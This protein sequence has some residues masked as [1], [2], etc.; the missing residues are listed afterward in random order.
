MEIGLLIKVIG[1]CLGSYLLGSIPFG[2]IVSKYAKGIDI[3]KVGSGNI[4]GT[5]VGRILGLRYGAL[6]AGLD[7]W[8]GALPVILTMYFF[9]QNWWLVGLAWLFAFL[10]HL[11]PVWLKFKGGKGVSV[12]I[13]GLL[14]LTGWKTCLI[15]LGCWLGVFLFLARRKMS[16]ANL[17]ISAGLLVFIT[18]IPIFLYL[19]PIVLIMV[20]LIWWAHRENI[21]RLLRNEESSIK[22]PAFLN[23]LP[24]DLIGWGIE[25]LQLLVSKLQNLQNQKKP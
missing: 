2:K 14:V 7:A 24:D 18:L 25:K 13:G 5:N 1:V 6:V 21:Q 19:T 12:F 15:I 22:L 8:K 23:K 9:W 11:F 17:I 16:A 20:G 4:G 3:Q 10:G